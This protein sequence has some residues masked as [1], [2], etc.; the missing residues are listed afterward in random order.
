VA[1]MFREG[2]APA[3]YA[4]VLA[5]T[6]IALSPRGVSHETFRTYEALRAGCVVIAQRHLPSWFTTG[7]PVIEVDEWSGIGPL[8]DGLLKDPA[9]LAELSEKGLAWWRE[10]CAP[11]IVGRYIVNEIVGMLTR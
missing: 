6:K 5:D 8:V 10:R 3:D 4:S 7:W 11:E 2:I 1:P 9:H